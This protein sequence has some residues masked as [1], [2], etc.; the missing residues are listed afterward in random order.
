MNKYQ[1]AVQQ[2]FIDNEEAA[3]N[4]LKNVYSAS[5]KDIQKE[6]EKLDM[7]IEQ[8]QKAYDSVGEDDI[9]ALARALLRKKKNYTPDEAR[10]T[11]ASMLQSKIYQRDYQR[12]L[13]KQVENILDELLKGEFK[14][15]SEYLKVCYED[16]FVGTLFDLQAQGIPLCFPLNQEAVANAVRL[17]S[18]ISKGLYSHLGENV[19]ELKEKIAAEVS[20]GIS[21]ALS[22]E[23]IALNIGKKML[24]T[25]NNPGGSY[26]YALRIAGTEGHRIQCQATMDSCYKAKERGADIVKMWDSVLDGKT[27]E[28]HQKVDGEIRELD[29]KFSNG[30]MFPGDPSGTAAEVCNCRCALLERARW[31]LEGSFTKYDNFSRE[32]KTF[33]DSQAYEEFK[34]AYYSEENTKFMNYVESLES[35]YE[36][37]NFNTLLEKMNDSEYEL[38][39]ELQEKRPIFNGMYRSDDVIK[40]SEQTAVG[41]SL[42]TS[43]SNKSK[44]KIDI[45]FFATTPKDFET[46]ILPAKEYAHVISEINTNITEEQLKH[47]ILSKNIGD[48]TYTFE[49]FGFDDYR[50]IKKRKIGGLDDE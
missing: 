18:Q 39:K 5:Y 36:T 19:G 42:L 27:R 33:E 4:E 20:R 41:D 3:V 47:K 25:Y 44:L 7:S 38:F 22:T 46:I 26:A 32:I 48:Y 16:G 11:L 28:S 35:R 50:I 29:E 14:T 30:L 1:K 49:C 24:G 23:Q 37:K 2:R 12:A 45:Q 10:D 17:D 8:L 15:I 40:K 21:S 13:E 6:I 43:I 34:K 31:A 9:G